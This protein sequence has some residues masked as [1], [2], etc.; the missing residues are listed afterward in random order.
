[1][2]NIDLPQERI[3]AALPRV[4]KGLKSYTW[5]QAR[6]REVDVRCDQEFRRRFNGFYRVRR[7]QQWQDAFYDLLETGKRRPIGFAEALTGLNLRTGRCEASFA[8]KL[9]ATLDPSR[10]VIDS[11][12]LNNVGM[13]LPA[14]S[15]QSRMQ[16]TVDVY[17][18]L[19]ECLEAYLASAPGQYLI[20]AFDLAYPSAGISEMKKLDLT[21]WQ[22]R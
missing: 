14:Q 11:F 15:H 17:R 22:A 16:A 7:N 21:L 2:P 3:D 6:C 8:S 13:R 10:P 1:M 5:L 12:V 4:E 20:M 18:R 9:V 19:T